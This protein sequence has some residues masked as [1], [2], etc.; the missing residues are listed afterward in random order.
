MGGKVVGGEPRVSEGEW[1]RQPERGSAFGI[2]ALLAAHRVFGRRFAVAIL[3]VVALYYAMF[4]RTA[5]RASRDYLRRVLPDPGFLDV[6]RHIATF[7][8]CSFDR[9]LFAAGK[10]DGFRIDRTGDEHLRALHEAR[11]GAILL[12]AHLGSFEAMRAMG[13]REGLVVNVLAHFANA[14]KITAMLA[15]VAP[16]FAARIIEI[17]PDAPHWALKVGERIAAGELVAVLGDRTGLGEG[18]AAVDLL[19]ARASLPTGPYALASV[20]R[21]P[22][23]LTFGLYLGGGHYSLHCEPFADEVT[24]P[25]AER[26]ERVQAL[27]QRF[28]T[29]LEHYVRRAPYCWFNFFSLWS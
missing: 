16:G 20:L 9:V 2:R 28:A 14:R 17:D 22:I 29:R 24:L 8:V 6:V 1:L 23:Y 10:L 11:R 13:E 21:C 3:G 7:A 25:R 15:A 4:A 5:R 26:A 12:G 19:G 18:T 27:A